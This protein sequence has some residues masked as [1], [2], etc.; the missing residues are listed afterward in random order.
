MKKEAANSFKG[1]VVKEA[2]VTRQ[3]FLEDVDNTNFK[4]LN[5][6]PDAI[7][8]V[9]LTDWLTESELQYM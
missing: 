1:G 6:A 4:N 9:D 8:E 3:P 5:L 7:F 2:T